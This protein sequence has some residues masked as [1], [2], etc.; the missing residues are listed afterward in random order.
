MTTPDPKPDDASSARRELTPEPTDAR[1]FREEAREDDSQSHLTER[2]TPK[3]AHKDLDNDLEVAWFEQGEHALHA[4][5]L[6]SPTP[7]PNVAAPVR[8]MN[9][10]PPPKPRSL[11]TPS[12]E[13]RVGLG[14]V[15]AACAFG[16]SV[17]FSLR[18][19]ADVR[20]A[21]VALQLSAPVNTAPLPASQVPALQV[22]AAQS[23]V[24]PP[25]AS[26]P[27][28]PPS[29]SGTGSLGTVAEG[30]LTPPPPQLHPEPPSAATSPAGKTSAEVGS[31]TVS[32]TSNALRIATPPA[33]PTA[34]I[35]NPQQTQYPSL[36]T[37]SPSSA[38]G[39]A[40]EPARSSAA[41]IPRPNAEP[42]S[43]SAVPPRASVPAVSAPQTQGPRVYRAVD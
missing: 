27:P 9:S 22:A 4:S 24:S 15:L 29:L 26:L 38:T 43:T 30:A 34:P 12:R 16:A 6:A 35:F 10:A 42:S 37:R 31:P 28:A 3:P 19:V 25:P 41:H 17:Y 1:S 14:L 36:A 32:Q 39:T 7:P 21:N 13:S 23:A 11:S 2:D 8:R 18:W 40:T 33:L 20:Q 5:M